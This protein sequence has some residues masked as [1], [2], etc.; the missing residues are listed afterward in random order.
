MLERGNT[1]TRKRFSMHHLLILADFPSQC[2]LH[3]FRQ[4]MIGIIYESFKEYLKKS[5]T[6]QYHCNADIIARNR[7][8]FD[9]SVIC[10]ENS[11][12]PT[13]NSLQDKLDLNLLFQSLDSKK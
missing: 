1:N 8:E 11:F 10:G 12:L 5:S 3:Y 9:P 4:K 6:N 13:I 7:S 2:S